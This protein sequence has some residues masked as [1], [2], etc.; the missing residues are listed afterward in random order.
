LN[1]GFSYDNSR[2]NMSSK[3]L[4]VGISSFIILSMVS[5]F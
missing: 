5:G 2:N 4:Q 3:I 1:D